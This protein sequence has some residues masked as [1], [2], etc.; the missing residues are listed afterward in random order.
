MGLK[1]ACK[2]YHV[3][4]T[5][6]QRRARLLG[7]APPPHSAKKG[8]GSRKP[9]FSEMMENE[10][11]SHIQEMES[12]LFGFT[13]G[14]LRK[15]AYQYA[16]A[17]N[18]PHPFS[19]EEEAAGTCI[20]WLKGF[21]SRHQKSVSLRSPEAT[22]AARAR[23]FNQVSINKFFDLLEQLQDNHK[24]TPDRIFNVDETGI[25]TVPNKPSTII[26]TRGEKQVGALS[27]A[28][29]GQLVTIEICM[30]AAG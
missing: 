28:E 1:K 3:P 11:V 17:N 20:D 27:S 8:L 14:E 19:R 24:F 6:L 15:V 18:I 22:S 7:D 26:G 12:M 30:S 5:T 16:E 25:T 23:G 4:R 13:P 9:V 10:L 2:E 21:M 29:R